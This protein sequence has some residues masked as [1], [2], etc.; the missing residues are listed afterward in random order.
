MIFIETHGYGQKTLRVC[1]EAPMKDM[2]PWVVGELT[3]GARATD[4]AFAGTEMKNS[5][6]S[7]VK[8]NS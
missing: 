3:A 2:E 1:I 4:G 6:L 8:L 5:L 7:T